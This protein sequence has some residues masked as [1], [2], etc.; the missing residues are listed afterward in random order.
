[1]KNIISKMSL[2]FL[3]QTILLIIIMREVKKMA[4]ISYLN[5]EGNTEEVIDFYQKALDGTEIKKIKFKDFPQN[6]NSSLA[7]EELDLIMNASMKFAGGII[8]FSDVLPSMK[9]SGNSFI[10]GNNMSLTIVIKDKSK[11]EKY[12]NGLS[13]G[14]T[15][16]MP[17]TETPWSDSFGMVIDKFGINWQLNCTSDDYYYFS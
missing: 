17:L 13:V 7:E 11:I 15:V 1:M 8:M 3:L 14:G 9:K 2:H 6:P 10:S 4:V 12:F 16:I 5:F